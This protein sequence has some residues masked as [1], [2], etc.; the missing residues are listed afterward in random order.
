MV[1]YR[2]LWSIDASLSRLTRCPLESPV[3]W[4]PRSMLFHNF[5]VYSAHFLWQEWRSGWHRTE[6]LLL[7]SVRRKRRRGK[8][9]YR[10]DRTGLHPTYSFSSLWLLGN[11]T[12]HL[13]WA[14]SQLSVLVDLNFFL[15]DRLFKKSSHSFRLLYEEILEFYLYNFD[16]NL[17][18]TLSILTKK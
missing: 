10:G 5:L 18:Y 15:G 3:T 4:I 14:C 9:T 1:A 17:S 2:F 11:D 13:D 12:L 8:P 16:L 7:L 6:R